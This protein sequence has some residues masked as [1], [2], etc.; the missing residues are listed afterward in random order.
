MKYLVKNMDGQLRD[1][2]YSIS[3][4]RVA[5]VL[6]FV[7]LNL[8]VFL[9]RLVSVL[10]YGTLFPFDSVQPIY[11]VWKAVHHLQVYEWPL[12]YPYSLALYNYLFY[13][14]YAIFLRAVG[15]TGAGIMTWGR[16]FTPVFAIM[17]AIAQWKLVQYHLKLRGARSALSLIFAL[18]LWFCTSIVRYWALSIRPDMAAIAL[19]MVALYMVVRQPRF[20]FAYAGVLFYL[21]WSFKQT[22]VMVFAGVCL[23]LLFH[24]R[25]RDLTLLVTVFAALVA[26]TL[27]L[28]TPEYR[29]N[30]L[31]APGLV[32]E[33]SFK[34]AS[35]MAPKS[36]VSNAYWILAPIALLFAAG[37]RRIDNVLRM[38][39]IVLAVALISGLAG[40]TKV[41][42]WDNYLLEAFV[43]GSTLLQIAIFT[44]PGRL[45]S[46]LVLYGCIIPSI[47]LATLP[48]GTHQHFFGTVGIA[49]A[50]DYEDAVALRDRLAPMT[51]PIFTTDPMF[52]LPWISTGNRAPA[53]VI[54]SLF[55]DAT[56][57]RCQN[58][59]VEGLLQRGEIPTVVLQS[60]GDPYQS[61][62]SPKYEK[63]GEARESERMWSIYALSP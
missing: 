4:L 24:K 10:R 52:S 25:W 18:G 58:G 57:D 46:A 51:K 49:T 37:E 45:V 60:S 39:T 5:A 62:L 61:S 36:M 54:D 1:A 11:A 56:R 53:L 19:V 26:A 31:V 30:V 42:S 59:C 23:F 41:G 32:R 29:F 27:L 22:V 7:I 35:Q 48:S 43:A 50:A 8:A 44:S 12:A 20:G 6:I 2:N 13:Y 21:A 33:F 17:G 15:V 47:Q 3:D 40:M 9:E 16:M 63:A 28:G 38:F 34:W 55:H 14:T